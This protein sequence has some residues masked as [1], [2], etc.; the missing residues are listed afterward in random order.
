QP[1]LDW[2]K[3]IEKLDYPEF[4]VNDTKGLEIILTAYKKATKDRSQFP[5][6]A[7]WG[8][9]KNIKGQFSFLHRIVDAPLETFNLN[10]YPVQKVL[11]LEDFANSNANFKSMAGLLTSN[12][13]NSVELIE[14]LIKMADTELYEEIKLLF[15]KFTK[16]T[17]EVVCLGLAQVQKPWNALHQE[18]LNRLVSVFLA[19]HSSSTPVLTRLWQ[20]NSVLFTEG[21]L[22]MHKK[23]AMTI[24]R[25][26]DIAQDLKILN[27]LLAI[28][29]FFF[30]IDL[31]AL[32]SRREYLNLEK[33]LQDNIVEYGDSFIHDCL[34][35]LNQKVA[36]E[37]TRETNGSIQSVRLSID[38][39]SIFLRILQNS[40]MS[41]KNTESFKEVHR[42]ALQVYPRLTTGPSSES[43]VTGETFSA[44]VEEEANSY[45]E[46]VYRQE[47]GIE[48]MIKL[49]QKFKNS[50]E[51]RENEIFSCMVHNL[52]DEYQFF[53]KYPQREL[54]ITSVIFGSLIQYQLVGYM[55]LGIAL[56]YVLNALRNPSDSKMFNFGVQALLR[57]QSRLPEWP[58]YCS[59]L[60]QIPQLQQSHPDIIQY[61]RSALAANA[62]S[63]TVTTP[64]SVNTLGIGN[65]EQ[66]SS[67]STSTNEL[68]PA[69][70]PVS[71]TSN[72]VF[73][74][75]AFTALN[76]DTLLA[77][78]KDDYEIPGEAI[79]DKILFIIN[80]VAQSNLDSKVA[81]MKELLKESHYRWFANYL[82][83]KRASI[84]PNYHQLYLQFLDALEIPL[85]V[86]HVLHETFANIKI[87]L[88]SEKTVQSP[89]ERSLL[90]NLG[91]WLG[92]MTLARNKPIKHKN[93]AFK[94][95]SNNMFFLD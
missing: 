47:I 29:P 69:S 14:T 57:F 43:G 78:D 3:V 51:Q 64:T 9:W 18:I 16:Q 62:N 19:G 61:V 32:A 38:V 33:W 45:Y 7:F 26:L 31:A 36:L 21:C 24:S 74:K 41:G 79:Q 46:R 34:E 30:S 4:V 83:V 91:S 5:L 22:E 65:G 80:N 11:S 10:D 75:P 70:R 86:K 2:A 85:L 87:L 42:A 67:Q 95:C 50:Q 52:F 23:D 6:H 25:I 27:Q 56:R 49:L 8:R 88:N 20:V 44:D 13:W 37:I 89:S 84:E 73:D 72:K 90:K 39:I 71:E 58:Q 68:L 35:F 59:H 53:P 60:L 66:A 55:A 93:I 28:Q 17:P 77:A 15:E 76:L 40:T 48:E 54:T 82:V 63:T 1:H 94:V 81:E 92:G 12:P